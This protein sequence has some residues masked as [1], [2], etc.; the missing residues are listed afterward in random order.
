MGKL[1]LQSKALLDIAIAL[2]D[3]LVCDGHEVECRIVT[4]GCTCGIWSAREVVRARAN[5]TLLKYQDVLIAL[6]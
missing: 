5:E 6:K 3:M 4:A 1:D 2:R